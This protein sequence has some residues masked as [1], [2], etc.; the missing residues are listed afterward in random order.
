[1]ILKKI[2]MTRPEQIHNAIC[3]LFKN[4]ILHNLQDVYFKRFPWGIKIK[5]LGNSFCQFV[6]YAKGE[7]VIISR[8]SECTL[9][10]YV[11]CTKGETFTFSYNAKVKI[12]FNKCESWSLNYLTTGNK[13]VN[14][15]ANDFNGF[16]KFPAK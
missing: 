5:K 14:K 6:S 3:L 2:N 8:N 11:N 13:N 10:Q 12:N 15:I 16:F 1:M 9:T 7:I 4:K